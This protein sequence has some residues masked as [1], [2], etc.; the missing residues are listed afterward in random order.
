MVGRPLFRDTMIG[1]H[2]HSSIAPLHSIYEAGHGFRSSHHFRNTPAQPRRKWFIAYLSLFVF[3]LSRYWIYDRTELVPHDPESFRLARSIAEEGRFAN[4]F[5]ALD[6]GPSA[7]LAPASLR[8]SLS[9]CAYLEMEL[10]ACMPSNGLQPSCCVS[11][12]PFS[13]CSV[14]PSGWVS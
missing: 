2:S 11:N 1:K 10:R 3:A 4:P 5:V 8:F 7:H 13:P 14:E 12:W 6:T 9:C